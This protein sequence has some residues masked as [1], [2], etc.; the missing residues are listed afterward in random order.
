MVTTRRSGQSANVT[1]D[2]N[3]TKGGVALQ[4]RP[5]SYEQNIPQQPSRTQNYTEANERMQKNLYKLLNYDRFTAEQMQAEEE[6]LV[7]SSNL[8]DEDF[9]PT[10]TTMQ[11]GDDSLEDIREEMRKTEQ[12]EEEIYG[13]NGKG[14]AIVILYSLI[15]T[16]VLALI[17][18]NTGLLT[19]LN[20]Q[21]EATLNEY[22]NVMAEYNQVMADLEDLSSP[23][24]IIDVA[25]NEYGMVKGN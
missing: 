14:K 1:Y 16:V 5:R 19:N 21:N 4:E 25:K 15:V 9:K 24:H 10:S 6:Q 12:M 2:R 3:S 23:Q 7:A 22:N 13:L 17:V 18:L 8:S 11:F 20:A